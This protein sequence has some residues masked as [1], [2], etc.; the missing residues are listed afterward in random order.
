MKKILTF[1]WCI[2]TT[3]IVAQIPGSSVFDDSFLHEIRF[4]NADTA[5]WIATKNYQMLNM[6]VDGNLV[7]SIGFKRKGNISGYT[8]N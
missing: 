6:I 3:T 2:I 1:V 8:N 5:N 7:D 4:E